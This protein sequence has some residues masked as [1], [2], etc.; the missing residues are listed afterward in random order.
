MIADLN[1]EARDLY[2]S[3]ASIPWQVFAFLAALIVVTYFLARWTEGYDPMAEPR[4]PEA[5]DICGATDGELVCTLTPHAG[6]L[7]LDGT[8]GTAYHSATF[9]VG[10]AA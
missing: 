6:D 7:H 1:T 9:R 5:P 8:R 4:D 2:T 10:R 3:L